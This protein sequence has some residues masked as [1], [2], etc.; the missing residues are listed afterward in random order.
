MIDRIRQ[1]SYKLNDMESNFLVSLE[2]SPF[3]NTTF[4]QHK[5]LESIYEKASGGGRYERRQR[6]G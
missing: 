1:L 4:K 2:N 5:W 6:F 3:P